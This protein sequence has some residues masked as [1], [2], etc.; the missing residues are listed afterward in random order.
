MRKTMQQIHYST[1]KKNEIMEFAGNLIEVEFI[2]S[3]FLFFKAHVD[4]QM[5]PPFWHKVKE[6]NSSI[7]TNPCLHYWISE[8]KT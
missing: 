2:M 8:F 6:S 3:V 1:I 4:R 7:V 5:L